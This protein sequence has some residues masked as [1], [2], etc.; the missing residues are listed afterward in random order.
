ML[1]QFVTMLRL[2][3]YLPWNSSFMLWDEFES[4]IFFLLLSQ[5]SRRTREETL[6]TQAST[7]V[8]C[9]LELHVLRLRKE[10]ETGTPHLF[11][12]S[13][14]GTLH[15]FFLFLVTVPE[16][17][18]KANPAEFPFLFLK[19]QMHYSIKY[20]SKWILLGSI[21]Q[22]QKYDYSGLWTLS[23]EQNLWC[24]S[25]NFVFQIRIGVTVKR[26]WHCV[27][28]I[29][30]RIEFAFLNFDTLYFLELFGCFILVIFQVGFK[31]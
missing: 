1:K 3:E 8:F 18:A 4:F 2:A 19:W 26:L 15:G 23:L 29:I 5:H 24:T 28:F 20:D 14:L 16:V 30:L 17:F 12:A 9:K 6:A 10:K 11:V 13:L 7:T 21:S 31:I 25:S 22:I 27:S